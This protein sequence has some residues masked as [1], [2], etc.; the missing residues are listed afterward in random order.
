[1]TCIITNTAQEIHLQAPPGALKAR[2]ES[3]LHVWGFSFTTDSTHW[4]TKPPNLSEMAN[5]IIA[6]FEKN[7]IPLQLSQGIEGLIA[8]LNLNTEKLSEAL[9]AGNLIKSGFIE[10]T[11]NLDF[12]QFAA[13][14]I[15]RTLKEHQLK[16]ALHLM[17]VKNGANF[18]V[19]GSGKTTVVL[20]VYHWL[21]TCGEIDALFVVGPP[22]CFGP[23]RAEY[24]KVLGYKPNCEILAGG[25]IVDRKNVYYSPKDKLRDLY[26]TSFQTLQNDVEEAIYLFN[27]P[28][29]RILLVVDEAHYIK[30]IGGLWADAVLRLSPY[31]AIRCILTGTPFP[32]A[33]SD[34]FNLFD[35]LWPACSPIS[36]SDKMRIQYHCKTDDIEQAAEILRTDIGSLFYRVRKSDLNLAPQV[37]HPPIMVTMNPYEKKI[38]DAILDRIKNLSRDDYFRDL[39]LMIRLRKGRLMR[40]RQCISYAR[41]LGSALDEIEDDVTDGNLSIANIIASYDDL[42]SPAKL[43]TLVE[44]VKSL[45][46]RNEKVLIWSNFVGSL[47]LIAQQLKVVGHRVEMIYGGTPTE[48]ETSQDIQEELSRER[49]ADGFCQPDS[50]I[51][52]LVANPAACAE[53]ISLHKEC[54]NAIYYDMSYNCAQY[55]QSLDRIHRVGGSETKEAHY[56]FL[57]YE[58]TIDDDIMSNLLRKAA[59]MRAIIEQD[60]PIYSLDMFSADDELEAYA[61]LFG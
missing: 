19:P 46:A 39:D 15:K 47:K 10:G 2:H 34:S 27:Q 42:E 58:D 18:S 28:E 20:A 36:Q 17:N 21:R 11:K 14:Q 5:K 26:L 9:A 31:A 56:Y 13:T 30:Q 48:N 61:R 53:S 59:H 54:S 33:F 24:E 7:S 40:L 43:E 8:K 52:I 6:Y 51:D 60:Y 25:N 45:R 41:L 3:Q 44:M 55:L 50:G 23:W 12:V 4:V 49:I 29:S 16:A 1:M 35:V 32:R 57:Q 22:S 38:Y 37:M